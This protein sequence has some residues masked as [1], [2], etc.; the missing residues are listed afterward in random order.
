MNKK[1]PIGATT[2]NGLEDYLRKTGG[3]RDPEENENVLSPLWKRWAKSLIQEKQQML[4]RLNS[5]EPD[6]RLCLQINTLKQT[7]E[8]V[9]QSGQA[10]YQTV[11]ELSPVLNH[12]L[13]K[14]FVPA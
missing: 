3:G 4:E 6:V 14:P 12:P 13:V 11:R 2:I 5:L 10:A 7:F 8:K 9:S 1:H